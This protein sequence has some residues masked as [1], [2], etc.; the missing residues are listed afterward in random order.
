VF[1]HLLIILFFS[2]ILF[3]EKGFYLL[4][5]LGIQS[6]IIPKSYIFSS[7]YKQARDFTKEKLLL[8]SDC[9]EAF[10]KVRLEQ[11]IFLLSKVKSQTY[12]YS[13]KYL[14]NKKF[15][16]VDKIDKKFIDIFD[17]ILNNITNKEI[18]LGLK[19]NKIGLFLGDICTNK[20]GDNIQSYISKSG[21]L[22]VIG[23]KEIDRYFIKKQK[24]FI[25]S[26]ILKNDKS[27]IK[28][29]SILV[30]NIVA[31]I[32]KPYEHIKIIA[33]IPNSNYKEYVITDTINQITINNKNF[34]K[35]FI[36]S[37]LNSKLINWYVYLFIFGKAIRTMHLDNTVTDIIPIPKITLENQKIY[38]ELFNK[39]IEKKKNNI[40]TEDL[41]KEIDKLVYQL[42]D[43]TNEE[44]S[45][46]ENIS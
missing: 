44:I 14:E 5:A 22:K 17:F 4:N 21:N 7:K 34:S 23:G 3:I 19:I 2:A 29:E 31:H 36:W 20:R 33:C 30:Q 32:K 41:E 10:K 24:G 37:I 25:S 40:N 46:I 13:F 28:E 12:Y 35:E 45:I 8:I 42:Y 1:A 16:L 9:S 26:N 43:L 15:K 38:I 11:C 39:I 27:I 6:Y 18:N